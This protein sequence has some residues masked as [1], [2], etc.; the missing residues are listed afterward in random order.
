MCIRD[1]YKGIR[2]CNIFMQN[3]YKCSDP[4]AT[5]EQLDEW[6]WQARF[7]RAYYYFSTVS[8][9]HLSNNV[10]LILTGIPR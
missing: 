7:A 5:Q 4:L 3:V 2:E 9:T 1:S 8:Y 10:T 6:Y